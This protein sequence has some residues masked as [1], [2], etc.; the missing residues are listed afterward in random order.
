[1]DVF[2]FP[3]VCLAETFWNLIIY[4]ACMG[5]ELKDPQ[6]IQ[7]YT[8]KSRTNVKLHIYNNCKYVVYIY[9][10]VLQDLSLCS[11][12]HSNL[13]CS[14]AFQRS[15]VSLLI[16]LF[17]VVWYPEN[18]SDFLPVSFCMFLAFDPNGSAIPFV[19]LSSELA[20]AFFFLV[21]Y[22]AKKPDV[23]WAA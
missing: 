6:I 4:D 13:L 10:T 2:S 3:I 12:L 7:Y 16:L 19:M 20:G 14:L 23:S 8:H 1:M 9:I 21:G 15:R 17:H 5:F 18:A 22:F 11:C